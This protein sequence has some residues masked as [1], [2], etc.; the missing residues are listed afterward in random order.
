MKYYGRKNGLMIAGSGVD[1]FMIM[2]GINRKPN[3]C[4]YNASCSVAVAVAAFCFRVVM[5]WGPQITMVP[6]IKKIAPAR[7]WLQRYPGCFF[8]KHSEMLRKFQFVGFSINS[9]AMIFSIIFRNI[10]F[11]LLYILSRDEFIQP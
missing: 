3:E 9:G 8:R 4:Q 5:A 1:G 10:T 6:R 11:C 2:I 7:S